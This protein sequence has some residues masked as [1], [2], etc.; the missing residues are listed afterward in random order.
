MDIIITRSLIFIPLYIL[1][2]SSL[3]YNTFIVILALHTVLIHANT[4]IPFGF[5][6]Y[7]ITTPQYHFWHHCDDAKYYGK[8]FAVLF[9][10]IDMIFGTY[11]LPKNVWPKAVGL[12]QANYPKGYLK[13]MIYPFR[14][15]PFSKSE[16]N[17]DAL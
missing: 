17:Q 15:S 2:F 11:Y 8:N 4:R 5:L 12:S 3:V 7:L 16:I 1:G 9:P 6:K 14:K 13:Q 10:V